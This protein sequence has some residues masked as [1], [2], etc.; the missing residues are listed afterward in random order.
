MYKIK[1]VI[2][3]TL[4]HSKKLIISPLLNPNHSS[5][6]NVVPGMKE[7]YIVKSGL[8]EI[9]KQNY[10]VPYF[11]NRNNHPSKSATF[12][13]AFY[14][15]YNNTIL[16]IIENFNLTTNNSDLVFDS[17]QII[18]NVLDED[19]LFYLIHPFENDMKRNV[20]NKIIQFDL[21]AKEI[22]LFSHLGMKC[23]IFR[24]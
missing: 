4:E 23:P 6:F 7:H 3:K 9:Y 1:N 24:L 18:S 22:T 21:I 13:Y 11:Y 16:E 15:Y 12:E 2:K 19:G 20:L 8:L 14:N 17:G 10:A 5:I